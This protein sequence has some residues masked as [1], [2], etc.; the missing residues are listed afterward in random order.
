MVPFVIRLGTYNPHWLG[1]VE[2]GGSYVHYN[3]LHEVTLRLSRHCQLP[4]VSESR[5]ETTVMAII[6][7]SQGE[8]HLYNDH[9]EHNALHIKLTKWLNKWRRAQSYNDWSHLFKSMKYYGWYQVGTIV[10]RTYQ[11]YK[12]IMS[13]VMRQIDGQYDR[14][15]RRIDGPAFNYNCQHGFEHALR[16]TI[17]PA[18]PIN[19]PDTECYHSW[20]HD[21]NKGDG[22]HNEDVH[23]HIAFSARVMA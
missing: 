4:I 16:F 10:K 7:P 18:G 22:S 12:Y 9:A 14:Q 17:L 23:V 6:L 21:V 5:Q 20:I 13:P 19:R 8:A 11:K 15:K 3:W 1:F 2:G